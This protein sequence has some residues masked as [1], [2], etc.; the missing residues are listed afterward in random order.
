MFELIHPSRLNENQKYKI[1]SYR[2]FIGFYKGRNYFEENDY[3]TVYELFECFT[4]DNDRR[5]PQYFSS[6][7][8]FYEMV[9]RAQQQMERRAL[10]K[11]VRKLIGDDHFEW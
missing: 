4:K 2:D 5:Y 7:C 1:V 8:T 6:G 3:V 9:P 11:I 10:N